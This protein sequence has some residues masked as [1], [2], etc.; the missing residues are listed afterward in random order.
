MPNPVAFEVATRLDQAQ[1]ELPIAHEC[2]QSLCIWFLQDS[3]GIIARGKGLPFAQ[4]YLPVSF[5]IKVTATLSSRAVML[6]S[7]VLA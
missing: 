3:V 7:M 4:D 5:A 1:Q 2:R 6:R